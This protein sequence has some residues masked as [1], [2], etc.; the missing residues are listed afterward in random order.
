[1]KKIL[2]LLLILTGWS[3]ADYTL[4]WIKFNLITPGNDV[5]RNAVYNRHTDHVL[6]ATRKFGVDVIILDA[7][8]GDSVGKMDTGIISGGTYNIN[9]VA[10]ADD[11]TI[12]VCNLSAPQFTPG[13]TFKIY[14]YADEQSSPELVFD[15][16]LDGKR[17][18]DSFT[19]VG[20]GENKYV[21]SSGYGND[22]LVVL[23]DTGPIGL[24]EEGYI[25]LPVAGNA[26]HGISPLSPGGNLWI[27]GADD[28]QPAPTLI[29]N[30]G[31]VIA[32][33]PDTL[34]SAGG[35]SSIRHLILGRYNFITLINAFSKTLRT[36]EYF[37]DEI[38]NINFGYYGGNSDSSMLF[39]ET[40]EIGNGNASGTI[41]YDSK[42]NALI[43]VMGQ[44]SISS[45][46]FE[47]ML[48]TSTPRDS[49]LVIDIDG[50]N[51]FF[52]TD[53]VGASNG[54]DMYMT[55]SAGKFFAGVTGQTL[56][57]PTATN[58]M[59][60][61][62]DKDPS[63]G[64]GSNIPPEDAGG[65]TELPFKADVV[66]M[67]EPWNEP[68]IMV[69]SI[70]KWN[71]SSW[72]KSDFDGNLAAQGA[73]AYADTGYR[74]L[75]EFSAILNP[76]GLD[77]DFEALGIMAYIA[78]TGSG[79]DV[80]SAFPDVNPTGNGAGFTHYFYVDSLAGGLFPTN[81]DHVKIKSA[82]AAIDD[83]P[84]SVIREFSLSQNYPNPFN[85]VTTIDFSLPVTAR[86]DL[87]VFDITGKLVEKLV[88]GNKKAGKYFVRFDAS[89]LSSGVYFYRL[90]VDGRDLRTRKMVLLK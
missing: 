60:I 61:A 34:A 54:R 27:N 70:Y 55:W 44:N 1:M 53:H 43:A 25:T 35:T 30:D 47:G 49:A 14:R 41:S 5:T 4:N 26:R 15:N 65:V 81:T 19:A 42:R 36:V 20:A 7:A 89:K 76:A 13:S 8:T 24:S 9:L 72:D 79:G 6:V 52:P 63:G 48:K 88:S 3:Y 87:D 80:L 85:P 57:D 21:Y 68:D 90:N 39:Y 75:A 82:A 56:V 78:E 40:G 17:Y 46:S 45:V 29:T 23:K 86:I 22:R 69:G 59:Y 16:A 73:L 11:G 66:F 33:V 28:A 31:T 74:K 37:E 32:V 64:N 2:I 38:G 83:Q 18:G 50:F 84:V 71:G 51:D 58:Y 77:T 12:Y 62:F 67:V 10:I